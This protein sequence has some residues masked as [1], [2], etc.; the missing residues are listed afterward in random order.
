MTHFQVLRTDC[1]FLNA[2]GSCR[3]AGFEERVLLDR[4]STAEEVR[5]VYYNNAV[6][7]C[8]FLNQ[9]NNY[10]CFNKKILFFC[11]L[12]TCPT[13]VHKNHSFILFFCF[14]NDTNRICVKVL[15]VQFIIIELPI[16]KSYFSCILNIQTAKKIIIG[17]FSEFFR[18]YLKQDL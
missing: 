4:I 10:A 3:V 14:Q 18:S 7:K 15:R 5:K 17:T 9:K 6:K 1:V 11:I 16:M 12:C 2:N 8:F 13:C